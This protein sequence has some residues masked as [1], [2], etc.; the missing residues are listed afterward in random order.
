MFYA[1]VI[2]ERE[3]VSFVTGTSG[4][5]TAD[6]RLKTK[7]AQDAHRQHLKIPRRWAICFAANF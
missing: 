4:V 2:A 6:E 1:I 7:A 5:L 3:N